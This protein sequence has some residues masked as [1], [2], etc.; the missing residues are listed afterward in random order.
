MTNIYHLVGLIKVMMFYQW[1][2]C[3]NGNQK[4]KNKNIK[5]L[6]ISSVASNKSPFHSSMYGEQGMY[7]SKAFANDRKLFIKSKNKIFK[8][9]IF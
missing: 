7:N 3:I 6:F 4:E 8:R 5:I 9:S 1:V 2:V